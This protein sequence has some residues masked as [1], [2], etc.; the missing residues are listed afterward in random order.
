[1]GNYQSSSQS[2]FLNLVNN[3]SQSVSQKNVA[4]GTGS[5]YSTQNATIKI[6]DGADVE[7]PVVI[8][9]T[10]KEICNVTAT[11][12]SQQTA[13]VSSKVSNDITT[14]LLQKQ[15][16]VQGF[17][18]AAVSAQVDTQS[19]S[20]SIQNN[21][22][23][24]IDQGVFQTCASSSSIDQN[25]TIVIGKGAIVK[26][27]P[28]STSLGITQ[29]S[30]QESATNCT[31]TAISSAV[32]SADAVNTV[33]TQMTSD[34]T[35]SQGLDLSF[36]V[37]LIALPFLAGGK[38]VSSITTVPRDSQGNAQWGVYGLHVTILG[39]IIGAIVAVIHKIWVSTHK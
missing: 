34:Q 17:L 21:V 6:E 12:S 7:C 38:G 9:Q 4:W 3:I 32:L 8:N 13:Q 18:A 23:N 24:T 10:G 14:A 36:L 26:C 25:G 19:V 35:S 29:G 28:G 15:K 16:N 1:M 20:Q 31:Q 39:V 37:V 5:C 22:T 30:L 11:Q 33:T 27:P 2:D